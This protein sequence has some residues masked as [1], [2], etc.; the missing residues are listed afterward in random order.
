MS[1][2]LQ[3]EAVY[4]TRRFGFFLPLALRARSKAPCIARQA[5]RAASDDAAGGNAATVLRVTAENMKQ[6]LD[7]FVSENLSDVTRCDVG[8]AAAL[9][10][11][12]RAA[13]VVPRFRASLSQ[14]S[15]PE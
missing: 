4:R 15:S 10:T 1:C 7:A 8:K 12:P 2:R 9:A 5:V 13:R 3:F 14:C 11:A 6:R